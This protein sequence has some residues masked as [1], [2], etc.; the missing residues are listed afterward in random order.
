SS[1]EAI[2]DLNTGRPKNNRNKHRQEKQDHW[3]GEFWWQGGRLFFR[4]VH[5]LVTAF[6]RQNTQR[7]R[8]WRAVTFSLNKRLCDAFD[9][10]KLR[11]N[12]EVLK[13]R[14]AVLKERQFSCC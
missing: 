14:A 1:L 2:C 5:T 7:L 10:I 11:A 6:L 4:L 12:T 9:D 8:Q 3:N 13:R